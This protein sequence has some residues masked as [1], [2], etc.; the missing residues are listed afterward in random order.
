MGAGALQGR[1][2]ELKG[3]AARGRPKE[4][5]AGTALVEAGQPEV[6]GKPGVEAAKTGG[7]TQ[8][9]RALQAQGPQHSQSKG[10]HGGSRCNGHTGNPYPNMKSD[11]ISWNCFEQRI[12]PQ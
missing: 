8:S 6:T 3:G 1:P 5:R 9:R 10:R 2:A 4:Y 11:R 12:F 7:L